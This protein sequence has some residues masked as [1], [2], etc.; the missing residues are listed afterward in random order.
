MS[1][2]GKKL[3]PNQLQ[4]DFSFDERVDEY[5][6]KRMELQDALSQRPSRRDTGNVSEIELCLEIAAAIGQMARRSGMS[7]DQIVDGVNEYLGRTEAGAKAD[8]PACRNPLT[9]H[10]LNKYIA[11]SNEAPIPAY[12]IVALQHVCGELAVSQV[13][14]DPEGGKVVTAEESRLLTLGKLEN[15]ISE[16]QK[17]RREL[18]GKYA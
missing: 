12:Y 1:K 8:P 4:L 15:S 7:R 18:K 16:M 13:M 10:M 14:V 9:V 2:N 17:L 6:E 11:K 3:D 5:V